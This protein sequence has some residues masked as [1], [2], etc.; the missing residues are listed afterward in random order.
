MFNKLGKDME[1][2]KSPRQISTGKNHNVRDGKIQRVGYQHMRYSRG[3][4]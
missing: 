3:K 1:D 2:M 4:N